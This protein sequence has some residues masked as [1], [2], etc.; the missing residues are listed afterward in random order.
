MSTKIVVDEQRVRE[1][2][3]GEYTSGNVLYLMGRDLRAHDNW[4]LLYALERAAEGGSKTHV[5]FHVAD[6]FGKGTRRQYDFMIRGL[7]ETSK[8]L[9]RH[10]IPFHVT[11]GDWK[12][13]IP[14]FVTE[15]NIGLIVTDFSP[16]REVRNWWD[17]VVTA[18]D[19]PVHEVDAHN[20]I[21]C[22]YASEKEEFAA[23]T[24]RPKV[25]KLFREFATEFP[26]LPKQAG[27]LNHPTIDWKQVHE[28]R[29]FDVEVPPVD[30]LQPGE[31]AAQRQLKKFLDERLGEYD[32]KRNDPTER[33]QSDLSPYLRFGH[34]SAQRVALEAEKTKGIGKD[35]KAAFLEELVVRRELTDNY[36]FYNE[37]YDNVDGAHTW[38]RKTIEEHRNDKRE[39]T[40]SP[41][42]LEHSKTHDDLWN[43]LQT[44]MVTEGK[45]H[46]WGRMY[47][48][49]KIL[50]WTKSVEE[51]LEFAI[52]LNDRYEL[53]GRDP[54][55][56]VGIMWSICGLHDRAWTE[57]PIFGK[58]RYMNYAGAKRK[59]DVAAFVTHYS[60]E[61]NLFDD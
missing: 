40:Y 12:Q 34:I 49:K 8:I 41:E 1:L 13:E 30:W 16:L 26:K 56:Y 6:T 55:G 51:A 3:A 58:I 38:A 61:K 44:Q 7:E 36:C 60:G 43:A 39:Y 48:A 42:E 10:N 31:K 19:V 18:V 4:A 59:F 33:V 52:L 14:K 32:A 45:M 27:D 22:W 47:W 24:F 11:F 23:Y 53:D 29:S 28:Y 15:H 25:R 35:D 37:N 50:E 46:G 57:R 5:L 9:T 21:P 17:Q 2:K 20:I 54:N